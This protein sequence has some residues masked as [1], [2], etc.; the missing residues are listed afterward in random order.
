MHR[1][2]TAVGLA[3][4]AWA[5]TKREAESTLFKIAQ[6]ERCR[7]H[8][9]VDLQE[10][11]SQQGHLVRSASVTGIRQPT[12]AVTLRAK[13]HHSH[14]RHYWAVGATL[15]VAKPGEQ[16]YT[17][18][19]R[20]T[21]ASFPKLWRVPCMIR[22]ATATARQSVYW[23]LKKHANLITAIFISQWPP[24]GSRSPVMMRQ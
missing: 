14:R 2:P 4:C 13:S 9:P 3:R 7:C 8:W 6:S 16:F 12:R 21:S 11:N 1:L 17:D 22:D 24:R 5:Q 20:L 18:A 15:N 10:K 23:R 19:G